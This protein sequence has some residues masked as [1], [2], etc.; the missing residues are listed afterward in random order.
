MFFFKKFKVNKTT[1]VN[2]EYMSK[3]N[4]SGLFFYNKKLKNPIDISNTLKLN[5][6]IKTKP[7]DNLTAWPLIKKICQIHKINECYFNDEE[8]TIIIP[9]SPCWQKP[10]QHNLELIIIREEEKL[11]SIKQLVNNTKKDEH[12]KPKLL[13]L[14]RDYS[15][16]DCV[17]IDTR[18]GPVTVY[19]THNLPGLKNVRL[20]PD[21]FNCKSTDK[22][23][24]N[25]FP[26][27]KNK[28][29]NSAK[30][31]LRF[32]QFCN[33]IKLKE[34][35]KQLNEIL[36]KN[37]IKPLSKKP[38]DL[39]QI[40]GS[41]FMYYN[42]IMVPELA[43]FATFTHIN[44]NLTPQLVREI[45]KKLLSCKN[46]NQIIIFKC[47]TD[48]IYLVCHHPFD[49][50]CGCL[51]GELEGLV[52]KDIIET[53]PKNYILTKLPNIHDKLNSNKKF[54]ELMLENIINPRNEIIEI[55]KS[56]FP[57]SNNNGQNFI[58]SG[59]CT[60]L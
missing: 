7:E 18:Y 24:L 29:G 12:M 41:D 25:Y 3:K 45:T 36:T 28:Y 2:S 4:D 21:T 56:I 46:I 35:I 42:T 54:V 9:D 44:K 17:L 53:I 33:H 11:N 47:E 51:N 19:S 52:E 26:R 39:Q 27:V 14:P 34:F 38:E 37:T 23:L 43:S 55:L 8:S 59:K 20:M 60:I 15:K 32:L 49:F 48:D 10:Y 22:S 6:Y 57:N 1:L 31:L 30:L 16:F 50:F 40:P 58:R 5:L 13:F